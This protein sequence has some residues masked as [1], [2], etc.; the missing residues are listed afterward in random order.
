M[1]LFRVDD[2]M[3]ISILR[4]YAFDIP[5]EVRRADNSPYALLP[6]EDVLIFTV[7]QAYGAVVTLIQK[8]STDPVIPLLASDTAALPY[9]VYIYDL[10]LKHT[11][12]GS[13]W[14]DTIIG[15]RMFQVSG[16]DD[17]SLDG[18]RRL[19]TSEYKTRPKLTAWLLWLMS[20]G[21][22]YTVTLSEML[23]AFDLDHAVGAQLD[24]IGRIIG[25]DRLLTFYPSGGESPLMDD[26]TYRLV[27]KARIV[28]NYWK[29]TLP[30]LYEAWQVLFPDIILQIQDQQDMT[31]NVVIMGDF[32]N[33]MRE[34]ILNGY[35]VPKPEGVMI[36]LMTI[37][38]TSGLPLF[39]YDLNTWQYS[40]YKSHWATLSQ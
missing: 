17:E 7:K 10:V 9:G 20:D 6:G 30:E 12:G 25:V 1:A 19:L 21:M 11:E 29:G 13:E 5:V 24:V 22:T 26:D 40:G 37:T 15:P 2:D 35:I 31:F 18:Y 3:N 38:D 8:T 34:L 32:T 14:T 33:L 23:E 27:I 4:G 36:N 39:A 16:D 28:Q